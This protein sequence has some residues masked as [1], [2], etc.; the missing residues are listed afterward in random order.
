MLEGAPAS[1]ATLRAAAWLV[2]KLQRKALEAGK[3]GGRW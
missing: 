2:R 1:G 3:E